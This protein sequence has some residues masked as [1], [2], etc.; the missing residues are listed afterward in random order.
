MTSQADNQ[1]KPGVRTERG[2]P[3]RLHGV[4]SCVG[5]QPPKGYIQWHTWAEEQHKAGLRQSRC[6]HCGKWKYPQEMSALEETHKGTTRKH[7]GTVIITKHKVCNECAANDKVSDH[8]D[9]ERGA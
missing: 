5:S 1:V 4:V 3:V 6:A 7:G 8:A 2:A 9:S